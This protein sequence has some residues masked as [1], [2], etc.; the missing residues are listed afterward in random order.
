MAGCGAGG[1]RRCWRRWRCW[2]LAGCALQGRWSRCGELRSPGGSRW[3]SQSPVSAPSNC[4]QAGS[5]QAAWARH[6]GGYA[7]DP[8]TPSD[9]RSS[10]RVAT[11]VVPPPGTRGGRCSRVPWLF[12]LLA[13]GACT[14][15]ARALPHAA[16]ASVAADPGGRLSHPVFL[17][18]G[19]VPV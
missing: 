12:H 15:R 8:Q 17:G 4:S 2:L 9:H 6:G 18:G 7:R 13:P 5:I 3:R 14:S 11:L 19:V 1:A 16:Q 10:L